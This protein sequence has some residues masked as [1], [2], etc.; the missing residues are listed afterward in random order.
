MSDIQEIVSNLVLELRRGT[1]ILC[2]LS[3]LMSPKYG[4]ALV[5]TLEKRGMHIEP[6]TLYPLLRRLEKQELLASEWETSGSKPRKY[7]VL[8]D[9]GQNVYRLLC[10]EWDDMADNIN[11]MIKGE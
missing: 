1:I 5:E 6:G 11:S 9:T 2:V 8:T 4:Y 7:Y 10:G 3:Q